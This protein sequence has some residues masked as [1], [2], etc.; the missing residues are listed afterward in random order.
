MGKQHQ[1]SCQVKENGNF[2]PSNNEFIQKPAE[3]SGTHLFTNYIFKVLL[4][5]ASSPDPY[6]TIIVDPR[7]G[8]ST[9]SFKGSELQGAA[10]ASVA[11][12]GL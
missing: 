7:T 2:H 8:V 12:L 5:S 1:K 6:S 11:P 4:I 10:T 9:W 3:V